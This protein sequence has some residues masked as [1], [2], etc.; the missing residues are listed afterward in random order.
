M[1]LDCLGLVILAYDI[2][3][4]P[5]ARYRQGDGSW[6][7]VEKELR[8]WFVPA[9]SRRPACCDLVVYRLSSSFHFGVVAGDRLIHADSSLGKVVARRLLMA[10]GRACRLFRY[11]GDV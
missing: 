8:R 9:Y 4:A 11:S 10:P 3:E 6:E 5:A 7:N 1:G 2:K